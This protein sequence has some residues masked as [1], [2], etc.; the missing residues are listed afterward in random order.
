MLKFRMALKKTEAMKY[1]GHL[2]FGRAIERA[3]RRAKLPVAYSVGF[4]PHMKLSFGPALGVGAASDA[5]Y[6]DAEMVSL[7]DEAEYDN[8]L[9][10]QLP[11][12]LI[13]VK[14]KTVDSA[15]SLAAVLNLAGYYVEVG[16]DP[17]T[18][19]IAVAGK[20][21]EL[22]EQAES[23]A[24]V[25]RSPKGVKTIDIKSYLVDKPSLKPG[26]GY[27]GVFFE[28]RLKSTG[29]VKPQELM[30]VLVDHFDFPAGNMSYR[31]VN[32]KAE[33]ESGVKD[34]FEI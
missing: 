5:E 26:V 18:E 32:L 31:R 20:A 12:G 11:T 25:R 6:V 29:A 7:V 15:A 13:L 19:N 3:L 28:L 23:V 30:K 4:N 16:V 24:Y 27:I 2:D 34:A 9:S 22:F 33:T 14:V 10:E 1:V 17:S 8:R 21:L